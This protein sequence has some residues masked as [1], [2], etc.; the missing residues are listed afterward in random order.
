MLKY[1]V[2]LVLL[3]AL[4]LADSTVSSLPNAATP[5]T[6][7]SC[8]YVDQ[9]PGTDSKLCTAWG[10]ALGF[11]TAPA[12]T[13]WAN[14]N[15]TTGPSGAVAMPNCP[16]ANGNHLNWTA[17]SPGAFS[18]GGSGG[19][20][21]TIVQV[22][23]ADPTPNATTT[24]KMMGFAV[25]YTPT[26]SGKTRATFVGTASNATA[27]AGG[28]YSLRYG[29]GTAPANGDAQTGTALGPITSANT[30]AT[31]SRIS[32]PAFGYVLLTK[33]TTYWWDISLASQTAGTSSLTNCIFVIEELP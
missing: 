17:G 31:T 18:C 3:P 8:L 23:P 4:A 12:A 27:N 13:I 16:D 25:S 24:Q 6:D 11:T 20:P 1:A 30:N 5:L 33:G 2:P 22:T 10:Q 7:G 28:I 15:S 26:V 29:T 32:A 9:G 21:P 19:P 14:P